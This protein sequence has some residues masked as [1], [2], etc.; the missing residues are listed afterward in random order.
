MNKR[1]NNRKTGK[2]FDS[3]E[4]EKYN[5]STAVE[6]NESNVQKINACIRKMKY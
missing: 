3:D 6:N 1:R 4:N 2:D 5:I